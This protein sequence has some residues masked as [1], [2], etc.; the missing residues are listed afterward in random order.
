MTNIGALL[1][2]KINVP[3]VVVPDTGVT[4]MV[5]ER[6]KG[7]VLIVMVMDIRADMVRRNMD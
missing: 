5:T 7:S 3:N 6:M 1:K 4:N 2:Q